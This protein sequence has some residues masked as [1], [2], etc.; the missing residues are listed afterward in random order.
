MLSRGRNNCRVSSQDARHLAWWPLIVWPSSVFLVF[1]N[2]R[3]TVL[4][5]RVGL[6]HA[7]TWISHRCT[8]VPSL[9]NRPPSSHLHPTPLGCH[10]VQGLSSLCHTANPHWLSVL[11]VVMY[12]FQCYSLNSSL[13]LLRLLCPQVCSRCLCFHRCPAEGFISTISLDSIY[14]C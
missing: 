3:I 11:H 10:T 12:M 4:Q 5:Y 6:C 14:M 2:W 8:H 13:F 1:F 9:L 7:S